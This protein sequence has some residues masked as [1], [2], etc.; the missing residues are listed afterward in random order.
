MDLGATCGAGPHTGALLVQNVLQ[1]DMGVQTAD[2]APTAL[3][4]GYSYDPDRLR[5]GVLTGLELGGTGDLIV[6]AGAEYDLLRGRWLKVAPS[7][8]A[9]WGS[10]GYLAVHAG[11][12]LRTGIFDVAYAYTMHPAAAL[13]AGG[14]QRIAVGFRFAPVPVKEPMVLK[15]EYDAL[16][17]ER[18][19]LRQQ[20]KD[21]L[22]TVEELGA[23]REQE[24]Q[25]AEQR[26]VEEQKAAQPTPEERQLLE[27]MKGLQERLQAVE[28]DAVAK[29]KPKTKPAAETAPAKPAAPRTH[30][31]VAGDTLPALAERYYGSTERWR[32]IYDANKDAIIRGQL[33]PGTVLKLP[34]P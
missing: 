8:G 15:T 21:M 3:A 25:K 32:L 34:A 20:I 1:P 28:Q 7:L 5:V 33:I 18:D 26:R 22:R 9:G 24:Q 16:G 12:V 27:R 19:R 30:T 17:A 29:P 23:K 4:L 13:Q 6:A 14:T 11:I 2:P 31:V 10:R